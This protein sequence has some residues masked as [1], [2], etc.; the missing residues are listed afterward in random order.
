MRGRPPAAGV[1]ERDGAQYRAPAAEKALD[2][3]EYLAATDGGRT[4]TEIAAGVGRS[5]HEVYRVIQLL[6]RRGYIARSAPG[7]RYVLT[8]KLFYLAHEFPPVATLSLAA[9]APMRQL[10]ET[11]RQSCHLAILSG[12]EVTVVAQV[13]SPQP[14]FYAVT[15]GARFPV[16][17]TSSGL[18]LLAGLPEQ[19]RERVIAKLVRHGAAAETVAELREHLRPVLRQRCDVRPSLMVQGVTNLSYPVHGHRG[20]IVAALTTPFLRVG[21]DSPSLDLAKA[22]TE[23]AAR[24]ISGALGYAAPEDRAA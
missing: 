1:E 23:E 14:M 16:Q 11:A 4:Q 19:D 18:V 5:L 3:L 7:D 6:E 20:E 22:A 8:L 24:L 13:N 15:L 17:E 10:A 21:H 9:A 12:H 2:V